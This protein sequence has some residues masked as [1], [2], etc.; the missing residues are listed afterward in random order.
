MKAEQAR[1]K[2]LFFKPIL[3]AWNAIAFDRY[4]PDSN[5]FRSACHIL[6]GNYGRI[7]SPI[8]L[9]DPLQVKIIDAL[10]DIAGIPHRKGQAEIEIPEKLRQLRKVGEW[11]HPHEYNERL[12]KAHKR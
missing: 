3:Y 11:I 6:T 2:Q 5:A 12:T 9:S 10:T 4:E 7:A 1:E 8:T